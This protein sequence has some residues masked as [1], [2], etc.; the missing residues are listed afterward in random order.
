MDASVFEI[1]RFG[2]GPVD[3]GPN[4]PRRTNACIKQRSIYTNHK[5]YHGLSALTISCHNGMNT[6]VGIV[7]ARN[8]DE[9]LLTWSGLDNII[10]DLCIQNNIPIH[11]LHADNGFL[12]ALLTIRTPHRGTSQ[13]PL[14]NRPCEENEI[15]KKIR[16]RV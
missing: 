5:K 16:I 7:S 13:F 15:M 4:Q 12:G 10:Y 9:T 6:V 3:E 8:W 11:C 2:S 14:N 1:I